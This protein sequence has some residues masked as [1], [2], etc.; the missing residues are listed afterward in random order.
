LRTDCLREL[1]FL[2]EQGPL[3]SWQAKNWDPEVGST[4]FEEFCEALGKP[5]F[6]I[7]AANAN[8]PYGDPVRMIKLPGG[9]SLDFAVLNYAKYIKDVSATEFNTMYPSG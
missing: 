4:E 2:D 8:A 7:S 9:L 6:G 1:R 5:P 3:G